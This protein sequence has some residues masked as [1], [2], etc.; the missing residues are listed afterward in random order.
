MLNVE[1]SPRIASLM[2]LLLLAGFSWASSSFSATPYP[3]FN[4][5]GTGASI[6]GALGVDCDEWS[7]WTYTYYCGYPSTAECDGCPTRYRN[8]TRTRTCTNNSGE[9]IPTS[10]GRTKTVGCCGSTCYSATRLPLES[11]MESLEVK[12]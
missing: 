8:Q 10:E 6:D 11:T 3:S 2:L 4:I 7:E 9:R 5:V 12:P 1:G